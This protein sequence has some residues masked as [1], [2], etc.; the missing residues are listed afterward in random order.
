MVKDSEGPH[1]RMPGRAESASQRADGVECVGLVA[2]AGSRGH[3]VT[4]HGHGC[5]RWH[6]VAK[7]AEKKFLGLS[8]TL[9]RSRPPRACTLA[10]TCPGPP[11]RTANLPTLRAACCLGNAQRQ[12]AVGDWMPCR[13]HRCWCLRPSPAGVGAV[14]HKVFVA[15]SYTQDRLYLVTKSAIRH[16]CQSFIRT[17]SGI[18]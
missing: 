4:T 3:S 9:R 7:P 16:D 17:I 2:T 11:Y 10:G 1:R 18:G 15:P 13:Q 8:R 12:K 5:T 14:N 6:A